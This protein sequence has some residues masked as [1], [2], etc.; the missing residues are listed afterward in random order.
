MCFADAESL[1]ATIANRLWHV[2][3]HRHASVKISLI[4][5]ALEALGSLA[6][7]FPTI[8]ATLAVNSLS[9]F[10]VEPSPLLTKLAVDLGVSSLADFIVFRS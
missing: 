3:G 6:V 7:K 8:A 5:M 9:Q 4:M 10:L 2:H 1:H